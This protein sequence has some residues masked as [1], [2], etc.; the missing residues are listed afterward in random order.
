[1]GLFL[2]KS[3]KPPAAGSEM[4]KVDT[5]ESKFVESTRNFQQ[6][7]RSANF[8][9]LRNSSGFFSVNQSLQSAPLPAPVLFDETRAK[10]LSSNKPSDQKNSTRSFDMFIASFR[11]WNLTFPD[12]TLILARADWLKSGRTIKNSYAFDQTSVL[13]RNDTHASV[14]HL[15]FRLLNDVRTPT[16]SRGC[17]LILS[18]DRSVP[19]H[20]HTSAG[21][22]LLI[23]PS[24]RGESAVLCKTLCFFFEVTTVSIFYFRQNVIIISLGA[25]RKWG[26]NN[27][28]PRKRY[29]C[30]GFFFN[31][32]LVALCKVRR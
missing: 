12:K 7:F 13:R 15:K 14:F 28:N 32:I 11:N 8:G 10:P 3:W 9:A 4:L 23:F 6:F 5:N 26:C 29:N 27:Q 20:F 24:R 30:V 18:A 2:E 19:E 17:I 1:M 31:V 16:H 25:L 21:L 22:F